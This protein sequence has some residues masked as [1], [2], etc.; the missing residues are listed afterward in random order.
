LSGSGADRT[1]KA[2]PK[3]RDEARRRGQVA[4]SR[5]INT[6]LGVLATF[7]MLA[8]VGGWLLSG[9]TAYMTTSL[10][11]S[12][13]RGPLSV[14]DGWDAMM[15]AGWESLRLTAPFA[16][17]GLVVGVV[18]SAIQVKPGITLEVLKP[19]F[20]VLNPVSG[21]KRLFSP[22]SAVGLVKDLLKITLTGVVAWVVLKGSMDDLVGLTGAS[23]GM[24]MAVTGGIVLKVG[25]SLSAVYVVIAVGDL[26]FER[27]QHAKDLRMTKEEV[28]REA[29]EA[30][31]NP[32]VKG[33]LKRRQHEMAVRRM[34]SA[35]PDADVV[36]TNPTHYAVALRYARALPAPQVV[37]K[38]VD[39]V[40]FR[41]IDRAREAGVEVVPSPPLA[42]SLY[43]AAEVGQYIPAEAFGAVAEIL[44]HVYRASGR[45]PAAA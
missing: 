3:R 12:G 40:A 45:E 44:A 33:Q 26:L 25:F 27:W 11:T 5:E 36:I 37:A 19:R 18:A 20:Q 14:P 29:K 6:G 38:G 16:T 4:R 31:V 32:E 42:R 41:I 8:M 23:P 7:G 24:A 13:D 1:E 28:K 43:A 35:V 22:R 34:M 15:D 17:A 10:A 21:V 30:D 2:T 39:H 9:V